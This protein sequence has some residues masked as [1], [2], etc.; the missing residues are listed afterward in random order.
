MKGVN[1]KVAKDGLY[2]FHFS[3]NLDM[4]S[5]LKGGTWTFDSHL[6]VLE[7]V[8]LGIQIEN[9][10]L[11]HVEFWVQIHNLP[12]GMMLEKIRRT[13]ANFTGV[14]VEYDKNNNT[15]FWR[16][17]MRLRVKINV[18]DPLKKQTRVKNKS[19]EWCVVKFIY[20]K[21]SLFCFV[22]R[23]LGHTESRCEVRFAMEEDTGIRG[24]SNE[25][26]A[27][28]RRYGGGMASKWLNSDTSSSKVKVVECDST[29][30][31]EIPEKSPEDGR[32]E[33]GET[34]SVL[35]MNLMTGVIKNNGENIKAINSSDGGIGCSKNRN[36]DVI[37]SFNVGQVKNQVQ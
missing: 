12:A 7:K 11:F 27:E 25:I 29:M 32:K 16:E 31:E 30:E 15:S 22:C 19:G 21:L 33:E 3:H 13:M 37:E 28:N 24:W 23:K 9:I 4:Q 17:Y 10:P 20:E 34:E 8:Q 14:L 26:R 2:L 1:I 36:L 18:R 35:N 5:V 6:L